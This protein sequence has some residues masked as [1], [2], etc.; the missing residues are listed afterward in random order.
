M[1]YFIYFFFI[2]KI[3]S[4]DYGLN[5]E[6]IL[7]NSKMTVYSNMKPTKLF[8][9]YGFNEF[10]CRLPPV[11]IEST[12]DNSRS[13]YISNNKPANYNP[14][15][16]NIQNIK[17]KASNNAINPLIFGFT[18][19]N[20]LY[21]GYPPIKF[22]IIYQ[23][24][25]DNE[26]NWSIVE[27]E[28][29]INQTT[30][31]FSYQKVCRNEKI[32]N[33]DFSFIIILIVMIGLIAYQSRKPKILSTI[34]KF[35]GYNITI[36]VNLAY[37]TIASLLLICLFYQKE[38]FQIIFAILLGVIIFFSFGLVFNEF[39]TG[40]F[41]KFNISKILIQIPKIG[42]ISIF[43]FIGNIISIPLL[44]YWGLT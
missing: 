1:V 5:I 34:K 29:L 43:F 6:T 22:D 21:P 10:T 40:I 3:F 4:S 7:S 26:N 14:P 17:V 19:S 15:V 39:L 2:S 11:L 25:S 44:I 18:P 23:C 12:S 16:I 24:N 41:F 35:N 9:Y 36:N 30:V 37:I 32:Y 8:D 13:F 20:Y 31:K 33:F 38:P 42:S 28:I 27:I